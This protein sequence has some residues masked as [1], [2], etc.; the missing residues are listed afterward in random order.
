MDAFAAI[1]GM[2]ISKIFSFFPPDPHRFRSAKFP[3][4]P[5][6]KKKKNILPSYGTVYVEQ[7]PNPEMAFLPNQISKLKTIF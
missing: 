4:P 7:L 5:P 3:P 6:P 2:K 1:S